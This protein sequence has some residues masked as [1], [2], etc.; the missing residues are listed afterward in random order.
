[1]EVMVKRGA[2]ETGVMETETMG[3]VT[4]ASAVAVATELEEDI[5][6]VVATETAGK[7]LQVRSLN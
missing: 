6:L 3:A 4:G 1:M 5:H 2:M 7:N